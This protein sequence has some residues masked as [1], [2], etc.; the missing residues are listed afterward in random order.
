MPARR[1]A[2]IG[3]SSRSSAQPLGELGRDQRVDLVAARIDALHEIVEE[4]DLG[5]GIFGI[6]DR[7]AEPVLVEFVEQ[8]RERRA[9]HLLLIQR[10]DGGE[11]RG[12]AGPGAGVGLWS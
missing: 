11:P 2:R 12:G 8:R 7:R 9:F 10:L 3:L 6:L 5:L 4:I 1:I